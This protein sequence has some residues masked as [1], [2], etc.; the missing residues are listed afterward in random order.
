MERR[1]AVQFQD[2]E[3]TLLIELYAKNYARYHGSYANGGR[4]ER[5]VREALHMEW[6][7]ILSSLGIAPRSKSQ[8]EEKIRNERKKVHKFLMAEEKMRTTGEVLPHFIPLPAYLEPLIQAMAENHDN[9]FHMNGDE[10]SISF[11]SPEVRPC[12]SAEEQLFSADE[13]KRVSIS[14]Y[15]PYDFYSYLYIFY[16]YSK[17]GMYKFV[18]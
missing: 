15:F 13:D 6:A 4:V 3:L 18:L 2:R 16:S 10:S 17:F 12:T 7:E 1:R 8:I 5:G 9:S 11:Y 14:C